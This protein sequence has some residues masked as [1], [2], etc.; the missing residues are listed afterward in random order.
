MEILRIQTSAVEKDQNRWLR[1]TAHDGAPHNL[2]GHLF[3]VPLWHVVCS[4]AV[5]YACHL[6]RK[7]IV[8]QL[9]SR[10]NF[11]GSAGFTNPA[12]G[13]HNNDIVLSIGSNPDPSLGVLDGCSMNSLKHHSMQRFLDHL[14]PR[15]LRKLSARIQFLFAWEV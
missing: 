10:P 3:Y 6:R 13:S 1:N 12:S 5:S 9:Q 14:T 4:C 7:F 2:C 8:V 11:S 15:K